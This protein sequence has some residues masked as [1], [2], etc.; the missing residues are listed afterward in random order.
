VVFSEVMRDVDLFTGVCSL[1]SDPAWGTQPQVPFRDYW[2]KSSFGE[3]TVAA[4]QRRDLLSRLV[5]K[6]SIGKQCRL[7]GKYLVVDGKLGSSYKIHLGTSNVMI[8]PGSRYLCIVR[9]PAQ[10]GVPASVALPFDGDGMI[11]LILSKAFLLA[12]DDKIKDASITRQ[13]NKKV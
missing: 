13:L 8:E 1:G 4:E 6:L 12:A 7:E 11:S 10:A 9:G 3:L 2:E 5:P